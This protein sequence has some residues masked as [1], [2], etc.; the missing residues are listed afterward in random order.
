MNYEPHKSSIFDLDANLVA[1]LVYLV[2]MLISFL[3]STLETF[4]FIIPLIILIIEKNSDHVRFHA[5]NALTFFIVA[6]IINLIVTILS[7]VTTISTIG[8]ISLVTWTAGGISAI[9]LLILG[10][11]TLIISLALF[12]LEVISMVKAYQYQD[13]HLPVISSVTNFLLKHINKNS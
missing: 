4:S 1:L 5:A 9:L 2:P 12:I 8:A 10:L 13:I 3:N 11:V 6:A 7:I